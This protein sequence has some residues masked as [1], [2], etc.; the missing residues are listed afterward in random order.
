MK[1]GQPFRYFIILLVLS[2]VLFFGERVGILSGFQRTLE[3]VFVPWQWGI[4]SVW[5]NAQEE[6]SVWTFWRSGTAKLKNLEQRNRELLVKA[7]EVDALKKEN[8]A[9]REQL[10]VDPSGKWR[11]L[12]AAVVGTRSGLRLNRGSVDGVK[13]GMVVISGSFLVGRISDLTATTSRVELPTDSHSKIAVTTLATG[14][15]GI[16][17][18]QFDKDLLLDS[19]LQEEELKL[20][21]TLLTSGEN[22]EFPSGLLV[23]K[24]VATQKNESAVFQKAK[25][26]P[27][28]KYPLLEEA[29]LILE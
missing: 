19:V 26:E 29:F 28:I 2:F 6:F 12:L 20:G 25:V 9:L 8:K 17:T 1:Q 18:G 14:A 21:D 4:L 27:L 5:Q 7:A 23:G 24:I 3:G 11:Y 16:L 13:K 10:G 22:G 15:E